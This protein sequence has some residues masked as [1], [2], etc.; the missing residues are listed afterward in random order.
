MNSIH[1]QL[2]SSY[3]IDTSESAT[4]ALELMGR[5]G[6]YAAIVSDLSMP[7]MSGVEFLKVAKSLHPSTA[8]ILLTGHCDLGGA[9]SA[10]NAGFIDRLLLKPCTAETLK[11]SL[12]H[13]IAKIRAAAPASEPGSAPS[14]PTQQDDT[15]SRLAKIVL[16]ELKDGRRMRER[17]QILET[18]I[19]QMREPAI[20]VELGKTPGRDHVVF[21]NEAFLRQC[22]YR[23]EEVAG[24][25]F[26]QFLTL[27]AQTDIA[28]AA[29]TDSPQTVELHCRDGATLL[30]QAKCMPLRGE[31]GNSTHHIWV[32]ETPPDMRRNAFPSTR[33]VPSRE[34]KPA[35]H[36]QVLE[37]AKAKATNC[38]YAGGVTCWRITAAHTLKKELEHSRKLE[39]MGRL[40]AGILHEVRA[41]AQFVGENLRFLS[42]F[43]Q[44]VSE[45][46][47][48]QRSLIEMFRMDPGLAALV[49][50]AEASLQML[51]GDNELSGVSEA[52]ADCL[53][54]MGSIEQLANSMTDLVHSGGQAPGWCD[55]N[56][57]I[58]KAIAV[59]R[60][61]WKNIA[62]VA[63]EADQ[64]NPSVAFPAS[65][66]T[67]ILV[68][69]L[70]NAVD[71]VPPEGRCG[72][73]AIQT[74]RIGSM[75]ELEVRDN[76][77]GIPE[78]I[79]AQIFEPFF[80]TKNPGK[81]T[82]QGLAIAKC[83]LGNY[84]GE[85][86]FQSELGGGTSFFISLPLRAEILN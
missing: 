34:P 57:T 45:L 2:R 80:T 9:V 32:V 65:E 72:R 81:G 84:G 36:L 74:R 55:L 76:G 38:P 66:L 39:V 1:R 37:P 10:V 69:L 22:Q 24:K 71:A 35:K 33:G 61:A 6:P 48:A 30:T 19:S 29:V 21:A 54:G 14:L 67:H 83:I 64:T 70:L 51:C 11:D 15:L 60:P 13:G 43:F 40:A 3:R 18:I 52:I 7:G 49:D 68:N 79:R 82:G 26:E 73:I 50:R 59:T 5:K 25:T 4:S 47:A 27:S 78:A 8:G 46:V 75:L 44:Q 23:D 12:M 63:W 77:A 41:P 28:G 17:G 86:R 56:Q 16:R 62:E 31:H 42:G 58:R 85:I 20:A 53:D